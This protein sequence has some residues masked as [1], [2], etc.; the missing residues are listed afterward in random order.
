MTLRLSEAIRLGSM[1]RPQAFGIL[2][3][4]TGSCAWG[5]AQEAIGM[6]GE[7]W[8]DLPSEWRDLWIESH[9]WL[10]CNK[11]FDIRMIAHLNDDHRWNREQIADFVETVERQWQAESATKAKA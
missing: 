3:D 4:N 1:I 7:N 10:Q 2:F 5:A 6:Q 11:M 9:S 8:A